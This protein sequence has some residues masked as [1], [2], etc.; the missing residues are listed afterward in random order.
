M[1]PIRVSWGI[2][3][4]RFAF[5]SFLLRFFALKAKIG[6][7]TQVNKINKKYVI[8]F[9]KDCFHVLE[10]KPFSESLKNPLPFS[11]L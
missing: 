4:I 10:E 7:E 2:M 1:S 9:V 5:P 11:F 8:V 3:S 6:N